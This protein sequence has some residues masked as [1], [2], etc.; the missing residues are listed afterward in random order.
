MRKVLFTTV[1]II[2][3]SAASFAQ[4]VIEVV[5]I[6]RTEI[7]ESKYVY[8]LRDS[9]GIDFVSFPTQAVKAIGEHVSATQLTEIYEFAEGGLNGRAHRMAPPMP[10][11][12]MPI[13]IL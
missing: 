4:E 8:G 12:P 2:G 5:V 3:L 6:S 7:S 9:Q 13:I 11:V 10:N 1:L